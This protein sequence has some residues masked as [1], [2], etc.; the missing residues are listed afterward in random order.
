MHKRSNIQLSVKD[1]RRLEAVVANRNSPQ[2]H[3]WRAR[4]VL[5]TAAGRGTA[6]IMRR[7]GKAKTVI[8]RW[9]ERFGSEGAAGLWRDKTRPSRIPPLSADV[10]ERVL[11]L[12][13]GD[14]PGA[15]THWTG[16]AMAEAVGI[17]VSSVQR[18][19]RAH[20]LQPHRVRQ[21]K[22]SNDPRFA[23]KLRDI[24]GL[25][26]N[27]PDH[28]IVLSVDE[29]SQIQALDRTQPGLPMKR[30]RAGTMTHDYKRH[31]TTTLFAALDV[32]EGKVIGRCMKRHRHQEFIRFLSTIDA[33]VPAKKAIHVIIDNY[34]AH[35]H[36][37]VAD[38]LT[39]HPRFVFHFTPTSASWLNAVEG[40]FAKLSKQRLK[41]GVFR[42]VEELKAAIHCFLAETNARPKPF[43]WTKDPNKIIAAVKRGHQVLDSIH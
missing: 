41:R 42:S 36:P 19:W 39:R 34:A 22:L 26:V 14:P 4:I 21:F 32:L 2:K 9:Q 20:G 35:K 11:A 27:P 40:F 37:K 25:Y 43:T 12:T 23:A 29:K 16:A 31:G 15:A 24:V 8:W 33:N 28:A 18:I 13:L 3:V 7:T 6:E 17:S 1:R 10:A 30:G 38:W 5:L